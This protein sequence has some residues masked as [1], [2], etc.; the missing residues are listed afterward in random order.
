MCTSI[1]LKGPGFFFGRNLDLECDFGQQV[2]ITPR[3]Y[4]FAFRTAGRLD[5]HFAMI[6]MAAVAEDYPLY[7]EAMNEM[8]LAMAGL[9]FPDNAWYDPQSAENKANLSPFELIPWLLSQCESVKQVR[10]LLTSTHLI[11]LPFSPAHPLTPLHWHIADQ[12]RSITLECTR[13]GM[14]IYDNP[15]DVLT[16]N[17]PFP[18]HLSNYTQYQC[19]S[20]QDPHS[21]EGMLPCFGR[22]MGAI[23][24]PGD[25]SPASRFVRAAFLRQHSLR[26]PTQATAVAHFFH[27]LDAVAMPRGSVILAGNAVDETRYACCMQAENGVYY[28]K[29]YN[30]SRITAVDMTKENLDGQNLIA[31]PL[32]READIRYQNG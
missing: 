2:V 13:E 1:A 19:L 22:G 6:G 29:T 12:E 14:R 31:Y 25:Y 24:L 11:A 17:P 15:L 32:L 21:E 7:A 5:R 16:N 10:S 23:G 30:N 18:F 9:N 4:S 27:L 28:Y 20:P 8:G 26:Q 3:N